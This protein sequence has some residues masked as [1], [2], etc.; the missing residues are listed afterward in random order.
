[1][2]CYVKWTELRINSYRQTSLNLRG[3][4]EYG[5]ISLLYGIAE[6]TIL[7]VLK[8]VFPYLYERIINSSIFT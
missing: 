8:E 5:N 3:D 7:P 1:M 4:Y 6:K 2:T